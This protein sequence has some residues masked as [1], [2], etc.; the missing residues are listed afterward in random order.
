MVTNSPGAYG[1]VTN[2]RNRAPIAHASVHFL[3][4]GPVVT[5]DAEGRYDVPASMKLGI[6]YL[7]PLEFQNIPLVVSHPGFDTASERI[8]FYSHPHER[9]DIALQPAQAVSP[10]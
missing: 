5:T 2:A 7:V 10:R 9:H 1:K 4:R 6:I 3:N 8:F